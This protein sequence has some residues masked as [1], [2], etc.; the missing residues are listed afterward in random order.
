M[1]WCANIV[2]ASLTAAVMA[3][4]H[5]DV[6]TDRGGGFPI[7]GFG[8]MLASISMSLIYIHNPVPEAIAAGKVL[9]I[10]V[11]FMQIFW[12]IRMY[13]VA[14]PSWVSAADANARE[15]GGKGGNNP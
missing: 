4:W 13:I 10:V 11:L 12:T 6:M 5:M 7:E 14:C 2:A 15:A 3:M 9:M 1:V 8:P